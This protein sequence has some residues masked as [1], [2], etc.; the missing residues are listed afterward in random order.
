MKISQARPG[1][2]NN[3]L[4]ENKQNWEPQ[5]EINQRE[6]RLLTKK[7]TLVSHLRLTVSLTSWYNAKKKLALVKENHSLKDQNIVKTPICEHAVTAAVNAARCVRFPATPTFWHLENQDS[8]FL[9]AEDPSRV[10]V[11]AS[12]E[13]H[14]EILLF[15]KLK[16]LTPTRCWQA[17]FHNIH[18]RANDKA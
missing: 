9:P 6:G 1:G 14:R 12:S 15:K 3:V 2:G 8:L 17:Q 13:T 7:W 5:A 11:C 4:K 10:P 18:N 16:F